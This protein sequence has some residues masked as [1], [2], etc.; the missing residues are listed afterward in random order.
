MLTSATQP[1]PRS[2][3]RQEASPC[4]TSRGQSQMENL[5]ELF[6]VSD[7][8]SNIKFGWK[9]KYVSVM[10][11]TQN[12]VK[13]IVALCSPNSGSKFPGCHHDE[14][15]SYGFL[16]PVL[17]GSLQAAEFNVDLCKN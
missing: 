8:S 2:S 13:P 9:L 6:P 10:N 3:A 12:V 7:R 16:F 4:P 14:D 15:V 1:A 11:V 5:S 17:Q